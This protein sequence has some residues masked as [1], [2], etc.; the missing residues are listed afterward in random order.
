MIIDDETYQSPNYNARPNGM[1]IDSIVVHTTE[2]YWD[3]DAEHMCNP[4]SG[5]STHYT[6]SPI[7]GIYRLVPDALRAWHAGESSY[8]GRTDYNDFSIG[9]ELSHKAGDTYTFAQ[10][11][12]ITTLTR[13]LIG[14]HPITRQLVVMHRTVAPSRKTDPSDWSDQ[15]F[16][17]WA[18]SLYGP[19]D[20]L[21]IASIPGPGGIDYACGWGMWAYFYSTGH[22]GFFELGYAL[23]DE[24]ATTDSIGNAVTIMPFERAVLKYMEGVGVQPALL[25]E[26]A[27]MGWG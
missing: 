26:V 21:T 25:A 16:A 15:S 27:M 24:T 22:N 11:A 12:A 3:S 13:H 8:A 5:V 4:A 1:K 2:G 18:D 14:A 17:R 19:I 10:F 9:V 7:G 6:I 20:P 23:A